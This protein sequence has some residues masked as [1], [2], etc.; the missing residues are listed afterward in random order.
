MDVSRVIADILQLKEKVIVPRLGTFTLVYTPAEVYKFTNRVLPPKYKIE[1]QGNDSVA[2]DDFL[3]EIVRVFNLSQESANELINK[4]LFELND[5]V[6]SG[7]VFK[8][9]DIGTLSR[10]NAK[11]VFSEDP[12][13]I[14]LAGNIGLETV[15]LPLIELDEQED[16]LY[17]KAKKRNFFLSNFH[18]IGLIVAAAIIV[19]CVGFATLYQYRYLDLP[20][21]YMKIWVAT[22]TSSKPQLAITDTLDKKIDAYE[23]KRAALKYNE[24]ESSTPESESAT[25]TK[26]QAKNLTYYIIAGSFKTEKNAKRFE[27]KMIAEGYSPKTLVV[28]NNLYRVAVSYSKDRNKAV[29]EY[30]AITNKD[31]NLKIWIYTKAE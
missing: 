2:S 26:P 27:N 4:W 1:F 10:D 30:I 11:L 29:E 24:K 22:L 5:T 23:L 20:I 18:K 6:N 19:F 12:K 31:P 21:K 8:L 14:L 25:I 17:T 9:K 13:S 16:E 3:S 15:E 28:E 7:Q